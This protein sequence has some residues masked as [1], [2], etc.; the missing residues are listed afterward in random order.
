[1]LRLFGDA[2]IEPAVRAEVQALEP[3]HPYLRLPLQF[4]TALDGVLRTL[5]DPDELSATLAEAEAELAHPGRWGLTFTLV[6]TWG[7]RPA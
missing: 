2:G 5:V 1:M 3:G 7:R 6:Q 4:A